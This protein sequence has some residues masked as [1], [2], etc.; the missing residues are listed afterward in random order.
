M[1]IVVLVLAVLLVSGFGL[2]WWKDRNRTHEQAGDD[3]RLEP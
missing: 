3:G 1:L 2:V